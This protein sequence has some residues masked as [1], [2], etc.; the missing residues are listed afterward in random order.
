MPRPSFKAGIGLVGPDVSVL[1]VRREQIRGLEGVGF[2]GRSERAGQ[3][4]ETVELPP[5][6]GLL[7]GESAGR[8]R[9]RRGETLSFLHPRRDHVDEA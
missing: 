3:G 8:G 7:F 5:N 2:H 9:G 4:F 1:D 6:G